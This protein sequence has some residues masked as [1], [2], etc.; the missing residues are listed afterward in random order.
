MAIYVKKSDVYVTEQGWMWHSLDL[1]LAEARI[2]GYIYGLTNSKR[3][4]V[5]GYKGEN[6]DLARTLH[7][8]H[9]TVNNTLI[10]MVEKGL[11]IV[12]DG[13]YRSEEIIIEDGKSVSNDGKLFST[14]GNSVSTNGNSVS[15]DGNS[16][17]T[18]LTTPLYKE[19][20]ERENREEITR[21]E[22]FDA[23][24]SPQEDFFL[25]TL[26][27]FGLQAG[28]RNVTRKQEQLARAAWQRYTP[29]QQQALLDAIRKGYSVKGNFQFTV[30]DFLREQSQPPPDTQGEP[31]NYNGCD[32]PNVP[33]AVACYKGEWG[34]YTLADI[35]KFNLKTKSDLKI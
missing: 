33:T 1:S 19:I 3:A 28:A 27:A 32:T 14:N 17:S 26:A 5:N 35:E 34:L 9:T 29:E 10:S 20:K 16:F 13:V 6:R 2:F 11:L 21:E 30:E 8:S 7:L 24:L 22:N 18:P 15:T 25:V 4:K 12:T 31:T 23:S